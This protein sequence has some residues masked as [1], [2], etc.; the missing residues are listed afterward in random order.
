MSMSNAIATAL[1]FGFRYSFHRK[2]S[3]DMAITSSAIVLWDD[4]PEQWQKKI[5][6]EIE[7]ELP[8]L[9]DGHKWLYEEFLKKVVK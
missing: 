9:P 4:V 5:I 3:A 6:D 1:L 8:V 7:T 2:T